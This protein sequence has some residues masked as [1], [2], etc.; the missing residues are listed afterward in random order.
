VQSTEEIENPFR[1]ITTQDRDFVTKEE[2]YSNLTKD[3]ADYCI[4]RMKPYVDPRTNQ[5]VTGA[6]DYLEFTRTLFC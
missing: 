6:L 1:A 5:P 3:M 2:L 4:A